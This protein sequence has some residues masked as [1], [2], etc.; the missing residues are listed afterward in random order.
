MQILRGSEEELTWVNNP[1]E[2]SNQAFSDPDS[3]QGTNSDSRSPY[4]PFALNGPDMMK[5]QSLPEPMKPPERT[6]TTGGTIIADLEGPV[7]V[8]IDSEY[9]DDSTSG[10][11][12]VKPARADRTG[13]NSGKTIRI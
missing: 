12:T 1:E 4:S 6:T 10:L 13:K 9:N 7:S 8:T 2:F 5:S 3:P 11:V